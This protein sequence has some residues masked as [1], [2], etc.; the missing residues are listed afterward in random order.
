MFTTVPLNLSKSYSDIYVDTYSPIVNPYFASTQINNDGE[1]LKT[2]Y[3]PNPIK[4]FISP[5]G[6]AVHNND[7]VVFNYKYNQ[8][9][10]PTDKVAL[11]ISS[12]IAP[13]ILSP[14]ALYSTSL[15]PTMLS[16][17]MP[18][19]E[20]SFN[21][22]GEVQKRM[23]SYFFEKTINN[24]LRSDFEDVL[25]YL[26]VKSKKVQPVANKKEYE[27][28]KPYDNLDQKI[29]YIENNIMTKY[30][31]KSFLKKFVIKTGIVWY[32]LRDH[33]NSVKKSIGKKIK[34]N[35]QKLIEN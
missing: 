10:K 23:T 2:I 11:S 31:M 21:N 9:K 6:T 7:P 29:D 17:D 15:S 18:I 27:K 14:S 24:W 16:A 22:D 25:K 1:L 35:I 30:D 8:F 13:S 33:K 32:K 4:T 5:L 28:N 26:I 19:N 3:Y 34:S 12:P 20:E